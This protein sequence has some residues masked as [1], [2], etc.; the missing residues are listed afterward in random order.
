MVVVP[1]EALIARPFDLTA[2]TATSD[3]VQVACSVMITV[4]PS[5]KVP[6]AA[7][8]SDPPNAMVGFAGVIVI[9]FSVAFV[10]VS[11]AVALWPAKTAVIVVVPEATPIARPRVNAA[12]LIVATEEFDE[13]Q[14]A[15]EVRS[16]LS[17]SA[18]IPVALNCVWMVF[19]TLE[20]RGVT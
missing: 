3:E 17:P 2:A 19:G 18:K 15:A 6:C 13:V 14:V 20:F 8:C 7:N 4:E 11:V 10:T 9:A 16:R 5:L 12:L 1:D